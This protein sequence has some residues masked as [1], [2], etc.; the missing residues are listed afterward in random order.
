LLKAFRKFTARLSE[1]K[2]D[3]DR[4]RLGVHEADLARR[5]SDWTTA[6]AGYRAYVARRPRDLGIRMRLAAS[7]RDAGDFSAAETVLREALRLRPRNVGVWTELADVLHLN[8]RPDDAAAAWKQAQSFAGSAGRG[9]EGEEG[10]GPL[11]DGRSPP[12]SAY[13]I[14]RRRT[15]IPAPPVIDMP[16]VTVL[17]DARGADPAALR[18]TLLGLCSQS[19]A[20]WTARVLSH[21]DLLDHPVA[22][23]AGVDPRIHF[24]SGADLSTEAVYGPVDEALL[25]LSCGT[26]LDSQA[27]AWLGYALVLSGAI[28]VYADDDRASIHWRTGLSWREPAFQAA[29]HLHD[30]KTNP[31]PPA[32]LLLAPVGGPASEP[33]PEPRFLATAEERRAALLEAFARGLVVHVPLL[34]ATVLD[35]HDAAARPATS[36]TGLNPRTPSTLSRILTVIPTRDEGEALRVMVDSLFAT[37]DQPNLIDV[38]IVNN[39]SQDPGTLSWLAEGARQGRF[40][41]MDA[42]EPFNWSRLNNI[43]TAGRKQDIFLFANNDMQ[44]LSAGWDR[45]LRNELMQAD[46]GAVGARLLYPQG[47]V[48]HAG[49]VLGGLDGAPLHEG[50]GAAPED[51][52]PLERWARVRPA[53]AVTGAFLATRRD[54]FLSAGGFDALSLAVSCNDV[55][56]CLRVR[57]LGLTVLYLGDLE[58]LHYESMT[59]GHS[60]SPTKQRWAQAELGSL[61]EVWG[62]DAVRDPSRNPHWVGHATNLFH[63][64][65]QPEVSE[66]VDLIATASGLWRASRRADAA[67]P[68]SDTNLE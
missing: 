57:A 18:A 42:D 65:R 46:I 30:M 5:Q 60:D 39:R 9:N 47:R 45:R 44:M 54:V 22:S 67:S 13:D 68:Q 8:G 32:A 10:R 59:R 34:L 55:D 35:A 66:V 29:A 21:D 64:F 7:H 26:V 15:V 27:L 23:L 24:L 50:L 6:I 38:V 61:H 14:F 20:G 4:T 25:H 63:G 3:Q 62:A 28:A 11:E 12:R 36:A 48:Q 56:F 49:L 43:A 52:G 2:R 40:Q 37:A 1:R 51:G 41:V 19:M 53:A 33:G 17:I 16:P 58:L 31:R